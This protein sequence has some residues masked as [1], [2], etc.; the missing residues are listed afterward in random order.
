MTYAIAYD[1]AT[2]YSGAQLEFRRAE[3]VD[4]V[5]RTF[6]TAER[7][8]FGDVFFDGEQLAEPPLPLHEPGYALLLD[9]I[10]PGR[11]QAYPRDAHVVVREYFDA[12][13]LIADAQRHVASGVFASAIG[14]RV[15]QRKP[16]AAAAWDAET[17]QLHAEIVAHPDDDDPRRVFADA[18]GDRRGAFVIVQCD[19]SRTGLSPAESRAR[20]RA[21]REMLAKLGKPWS[22]LEGLATRCRFR[23]G[24]V[25][26]AQLAR[27]VLVDHHA[28]V[29]DA[30]PLLDSIT[31]DDGPP[32]YT[33]GF[34]DAAA[35]DGW[36]SRIR[37]V[38]LRAD[39]LGDQFAGMFGGLR[40]LELANATPAHAHVLVAS[41][42]LGK[43]E[44]LRL[45]GHQLGTDAI[46]ALVAAAPKL[47]VLDISTRAW[48]SRSPTRFA[49]C[50]SA[51]P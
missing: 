19:L 49:S 26:A 46:D 9:R 7:A 10:A 43:L 3:G 11:P 45:P 1:V 20:R 37:G 25:E 13:A 17:R 2:S 27:D 21:Q 4:H 48:R 15:S 42:E 14:I 16:A 47:Q 8:W 24:F 41:G 34:L 5:A 29:F 23:R 40:A 39:Q 33:R 38:S 6:A 22:R 31:L 32:T 12:A 51:P 35:R 30:A 36:W 28:R 50:R 44:T 18:L